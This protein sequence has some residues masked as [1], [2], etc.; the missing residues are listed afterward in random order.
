MSAKETAAV[1]YPATRGCVG[2]KLILLKGIRGGKW[3]GMSMIQSGDPGQQRGFLA[4]LTYAGG[5]VS[6]QQLSGSGRKAE[7]WQKTSSAHS[8]PDGLS[9]TLVC[10]G[11]WPNLF[12]LRAYEAPGSL[13]PLPA[14]ETGASSENSE[15]GSSIVSLVQPPRCAECPTT[16]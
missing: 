12:Y 6:P 5:H 10:L 14:L 15:P 7:R 4:A 11:T 8:S 3:S 16:V 13:D 2:S 1:P 9:A